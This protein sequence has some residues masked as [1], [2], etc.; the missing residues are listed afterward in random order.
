MRLA[1][2][3]PVAAKLLSEASSASPI[4]TGGLVHSASINNRHMNS[5]PLLYVDRVAFADLVS[6]VGATV[7]SAGIENDC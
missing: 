5:S 2:A 6:L 4:A 1:L 7:S 3:V